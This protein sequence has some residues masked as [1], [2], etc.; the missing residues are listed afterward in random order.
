MLD[1][2]LKP[3]ES[4]GDEALET[5]EAIEGEASSSVASLPWSAMLLG[6]STHRCGTR[7]S[8]EGQA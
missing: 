3:T 6:R 5:V 2:A 1:A 7:M 8:P 4:A